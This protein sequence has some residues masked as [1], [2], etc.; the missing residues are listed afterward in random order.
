MNSHK[1][2][3][4]KIPSRIPFANLQTYCTVDT[5]GCIQTGSNF[6][7]RKTRHFWRPIRVPPRYSC[8]LLRNFARPSFPSFFGWSCWFVAK[9]NKIAKQTDRWMKI[10][11][12]H[13]CLRLRTNLEP[14]IAFCGLIWVIFWSPFR[15]PF[16]GTV[17]GPYNYKQNPGP[18]NHAQKWNPKQGPKY[19]PNQAPKCNPG[20]QICTE[21][22]RTCRDDLH[23]AV[24]LLG[25]L[26]QVCNKPSTKEGRETWAGK[27][28][29]TKSM[30]TFADQ[31][32]LEG[33]PNGHHILPPFQPPKIGPLHC[34]ICQHQHSGNLQTK[35]ERE[36]ERR[37][38][39]VICIYW[40]APPL[41]VQ[42]L[43][44]F[45]TPKTGMEQIEQFNMSP[46][47]D[48]HP[49]KEY[50]CIYSIYLKPDESFVYVRAQR[51][52]TLWLQTT[53]QES[54]RY[55]SYARC[56]FEIFEVFSFSRADNAFEI[57][58]VFEVFRLLCNLQYELVFWDFW[59][60]QF[61]S[62]WQGVWDLFVQRGL[63]I[64]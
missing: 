34:H 11:S 19:D 18:Q 53:P 12:T 58:E 21:R 41:G 22:K 46:G 1:I 44:T 5:K 43:C 42:I 6:G 49:V 36:R 32:Y 17:L 40:G 4:S 56:H 59:G 8:S 33:T 26:I 29:Q 25:D 61:Q 64:L 27:I 50:Q 45:P 35:S 3:T 13:P 37:R 57:F 62:R 28:A 55:A 39:Y 14:R 47:V 23:S 63:G 38:M 2:N 24:G 20:P 30:N 15:V 9:L 60:F 48:F 10:I 16:L 31:T 54:A 7:T 52:P 51:V